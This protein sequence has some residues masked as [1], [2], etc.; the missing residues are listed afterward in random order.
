MIMSRRTELAGNLA[1]IG[2]KECIQVL[3]S[4]T[5]RKETTWETKAEEDT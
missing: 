2:R 4:K 1:G 5:R 3:G